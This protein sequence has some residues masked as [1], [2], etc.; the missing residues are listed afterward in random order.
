[1]I[2]VFKASLNL[3]LD[4]SVANEIIRRVSENKFKEALNIRPDYEYG[5]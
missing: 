4:V 5:Q 2:L 3:F 1:L